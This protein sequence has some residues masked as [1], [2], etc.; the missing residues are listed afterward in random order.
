MNFQQF[1]THSFS[2]HGEP[3]SDTGRA[4]PGEDISSADL[5]KL[6][7]QIASRDQRV[8]V[9]FA[10][11]DWQEIAREEQKLKRYEPFNRETLDC[12][13][14]DAEFAAEEETDLERSNFFRMLANFIKKS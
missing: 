3:D 5:A 9:G 4:A 8:P 6:S 7:E 12:E 14:Y 11:V 10:D 2:R 1:F 13:A